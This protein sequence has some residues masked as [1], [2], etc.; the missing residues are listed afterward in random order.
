MSIQTFKLPDLGE[1]LPEAE[2]VSWHVQVGDLIKVDQAMI[3]VE[4]A[5]AVVEVPSPFTGIVTKLY[6][7]EGDLIKTYA[8]LIDVDTKSTTSKSNNITEEAL[9]S[10]MTENDS[11]TH[12]PCLLYTSPSPRDATLSRMPS[13]A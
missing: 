11:V 7:S 6:G 1:G 9:S 4:T 13:S 8:A 2:I 10:T 3:S 5:K 12:S